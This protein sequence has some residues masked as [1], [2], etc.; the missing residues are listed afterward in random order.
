[1][2]AQAQTPD[3]TTR[4]YYVAADEVEWDFMPSGSDR[5]QGRPLE[6]LMAM[7]VAD[8]VA[9]NPGTWLFHRHVREHNDFGMQAL[10][11]VMPLEAEGGS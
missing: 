11:T 2:Q 3:G 1:M 4:T 6:D 5:V 7:L 8:M 10:F 9:D